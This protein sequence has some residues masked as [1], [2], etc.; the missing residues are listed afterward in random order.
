MLS[1]S[2][3]RVPIVLE[4]ALACALS[5]GCGDDSGTDAT[6]VPR[7]EILVDYNCGDGRQAVVAPLLARD[8]AL[9]QDGNL[10]L[11]E[12]DRVPRVDTRTGVISTVEGTVLATC[13]GS[14]PGFPC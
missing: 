8:V 5:A 3:P 6:R 2:S 7:L 1:L 9:D 12:Y 13:D 11:A 14:L 4:L 10:L